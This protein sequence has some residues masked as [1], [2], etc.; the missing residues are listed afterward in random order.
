MPRKINWGHNAW[1]ESRKTT[2]QSMTLK[3]KKT[4]IEYK[5]AERI[6]ERIVSTEYIIRFLGS[7]K[8]EEKISKNF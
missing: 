4:T 6:Y 2:N 1:E 7:P 5:V 3:T 8:F